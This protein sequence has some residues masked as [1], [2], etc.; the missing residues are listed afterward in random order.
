V[1]SVG[2]AS[3]YSVYRVTGGTVTAES[4]PVLL[5]T[6]ATTTFVDNEELPNGVQFTY[7]VKATFTD[8]TVSGASNFAT[9][10]AVNDAPIAIVNA[11]TTNEDTVLTGNV[12]VNDTDADNPPAA[13]A[14]V[15]R[16][17][18]FADGSFLAP[19]ADYNGPDS[20]TYRCPLG[21][22]PSPDS[23]WRDDLIARERP[24]SFTGTGR[25]QQRR[26]RTV[27]PGRPRS[28]RTANE[29]HKLSSSRPTSVVLGN[30]RFRPRH[31][32]VHAGTNAA[33][34]QIWCSYRTTATARHGAD[35]HIT[36][37]QRRRAS[38]GPN[39]TVLENAGPSGLWRPRQPGPPAKRSDGISSSRTVTP[40][41]SRPVVRP[42][43]R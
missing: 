40:R 2:T 22:N 38:A 30:R 3:S 19:A 35:V 24:P 4:V 33:G 29:A 13:V 12:V 7:F 14:L 16:H 18:A 25:F 15:G 39:Q 37:R 9:V 28:A 1:P 17:G 10:T 23:A 21:A 11:F 32:G 6:T 27:S 20:F 41:C 31:T 5:G 36:V 42:V 34:R 8:E 43:A 26:A